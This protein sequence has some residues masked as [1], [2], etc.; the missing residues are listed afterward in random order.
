MVNDDRTILTRSLVKEA[1][2]T[3][4]R[5]DSFKASRKLC[6]LIRPG[7]AAIF[8]PTSPITSNHVQSVSDAIHV[9]FIETRWDYDFKRADFSISIHPHPSVIGKAFADFIKASGWRSCVIIY[10]NEEGLV[11]LQELLKLTKTFKDFAVTLKQ[12]TE[13][14]LDYRPLLKEIKKSEETHIV[15]DCDFERIPGILEQADQIELLT[16]YHNYLITSIDLDKINFQQY[17]HSV[18]PYKYPLI[19]VTHLLDWARHLCEGF[20]LLP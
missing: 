17:S 12:L 6:E 10:Q 1:L 13:N 11:K 4:P 18:R 7:V 15:L 14:T 9:P 8:G 3:Y 19:Q 16:D 2:G 5:D 20:S